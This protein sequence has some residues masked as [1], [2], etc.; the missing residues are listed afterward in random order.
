MRSAL[1]ALLLF[2][3]GA[4][5]ELM[6]FN[7]G[8][9]KGQYQ[10][11]GYPDD[12]LLRE[13]VGTPTHDVNGDLRLLVGGNH[14]RFDWKADYQLVGRSGDSLEL[15]RAL[16]GS[17][18]APA[19]DLNDDRRLMDLTHTLSDHDDYVLVHR[20]DRLHAGYTGDQ[21][22]L[23]VGR[24]AIS[25]GNGLIYNPVDFFNPFDP[26]AVDK[27]YKSGDDMLY[28]QY[29]QNSGNDFEFVSVWR[30][31][32]NG[33]TGNEVNT[34]TLKYHAFIGEGE[35]DLVAARHYEDDILSA[36]GLSN[37]GG[38]IVRGD[39]LV[40]HTELDTYASAVINL[41]YSWVGLGKNISGVIEY[42]FNG[43]GL[44]ESNYNQ[45]EQN[46]DLTDRLQRGELFTLGRHYLAGGL[47]IEVTPLF[48]F[49][50]NMFFN[51]GD[52][53]GLLQLVGNYD[54]A[55]DW[56]LLVAGN[57]PFGGD[58][59]EFGG[60]D[61]PIDNLQFSSGPSLFAQI[62]FYF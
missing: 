27:E 20:L 52:S 14:D 28:G 3:C 35:L 47:S 42:F 18:L 29:L 60:L 57:V 34:Q 44:R 56:Q 39:A 32:E 50:P 19:A 54:L 61:T 49:T 12:S 58:G 62:A 13:L 23:R 16:Q 17:F 5:A 48:I 1:I 21:A 45:L 41:S 37:L 7:S 53:S 36:G 55:Q 6:Q 43:M 15:N 22:V 38:A 25:W 2:A 8:H 30:R 11:G 31:D 33:N 40:T 9:A 26:A 4:R 46:Q 59:T 24:Q 51:L 10:V